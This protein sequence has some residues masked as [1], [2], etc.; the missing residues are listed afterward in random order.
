MIAIVVAHLVFGIAAVVVG[1]RL[2]H[3]VFLLAAIAPLLSVIWA[4]TKVGEIRGGGTVRETIRWVPELGITIDLRLDGFALLMLALVSGVGVLV[5][6]YA[7]RYFDHGVESAG[8]LAGTLVVF[9]GAMLGLVLA[10]NLLWLYVCWELTS[11]TSYLLIGHEDREPKARAAALQALLITGMGGLAMLGGFVLLGVSQGTFRIS[12]LVADPASGGLIT[13][14]AVLVLLGAFTKSAQVPFHS[15]LPGAMVASTPISAYLHSAAMVKAGIFL[16]LRLGPAFAE[17]ATWRTLAVSF[18][19]ATMLVGGLRALRQHDL[20]LLLAFG[21]VSQLGLLMTLAGLG[22]PDAVIAACALL[23]AHA[24]FKAAL[25]MVVGIIDHHT[26]S[27]DLRVLGGFGPGW[28]P[29]IV[30]ATISAASMAGLM[31][32]AGFIS[33]EAALEAVVHGDALTKVALVGIVLGSI[34][35][36][37]Y[38]IRFVWGAFAAKPTGTASAPVA[39]SADPP[40]V[41]FLAPAALLAAITVLLGVWTGVY[42]EFVR[43]AA[44]A[45]DPAAKAKLALWHGLNL[46]LA[47]SITAIAFG[48]VVFAARGRLDPLQQRLRSRW[49]AAGGYEAS[50]RGL[51]AGADRITSIA[52]PGSLPIYAGIILLTAVTVPGVALIVLGVWPGWPQWL[53]TSA[54]LPVAAMLLVGGVGAAVATRRFTSALFLGLVGYGM[55]LLFVVQGAP[56]LALTQFAIETLTVVLFLLVLRFLPDRFQHR[57]SG[58]NRTFRLAVSAAVGVFVFAVI[59]IASAARTAPPVSYEMVERSL[60][61]AG[62]RNVVNVILVDFRGYDTLGEITVLLVAAIGAVTLARVGRRRDGPPSAVPEEVSA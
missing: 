32:L 42:S 36:V 20:K 21:T 7:Y 33:K 26:H 17:T 57:A 38:S 30:V 4:A 40:S 10:D 11:V 52:Q 41:W 9:S 44:L 37:A 54:H 15:W 2:G 29:T 12:E 62:G 3:R 14:A 19:L 6:V 53:S 28:R 47:L 18:G 59:I 24:A 5:F 43:V 22:S 51:L 8:K 45:V 46:P 48:A 58:L 31:P 16:V 27:R 56:D 25:F 23:L 35:T 34:L 49:T 50:V 39:V 55:T 60:S 1:R 13:A 61:D